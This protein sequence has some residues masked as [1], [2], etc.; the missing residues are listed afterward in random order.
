LEL[1][2]GYKLEPASELERES[3]WL[4]ASASASEYRLAQE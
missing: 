2:S 4:P 3:E 1:A